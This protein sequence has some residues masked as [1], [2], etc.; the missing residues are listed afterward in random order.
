[1]QAIDKKTRKLFTIYGGLHPNSDVDR[2]YLPRNDRG[3]D[4]IAIEDCVE[5][6]IKGLG[7]YVHGGEE[8][9]LVAPRED[10]EDGLEALSVLKKAKNEKRLQY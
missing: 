7:V 5:L 1:M 10:R 6:A 2:L 3:R 4:L 8:R 9:L